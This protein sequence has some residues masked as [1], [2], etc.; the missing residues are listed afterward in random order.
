MQSEISYRVVRSFKR[1][2]LVLAAGEIPHIKGIEKS[3]EHQN[4]FSCC[5]SFLSSN[6][7]ERFSDRLTEDLH[8]HCKIKRI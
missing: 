8:V 1:L 6:K 5:T 3:I 2:P 7:F 4:K